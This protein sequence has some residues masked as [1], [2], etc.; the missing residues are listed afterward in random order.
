MK[1]EAL[2]QEEKDRL[3]LTINAMTYTGNREFNEV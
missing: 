3:D 1:S 2:S